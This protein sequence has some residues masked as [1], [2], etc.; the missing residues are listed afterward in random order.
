M[1]WGGRGRLHH[2]GRNIELGGLGRTGRTGGLADAV[3][4]GILDGADWGRRGEWRT[5]GRSRLRNSG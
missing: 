5:S 4:Y 1:D 2:S 3:E